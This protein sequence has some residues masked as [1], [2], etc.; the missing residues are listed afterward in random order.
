MTKNSVKKNEDLEKTNI[1]DVFKELKKSP[2]YNLSMSSLENFHTNFLVW[3]G[4]TYKKETLNLLNSMLSQREQKIEINEFKNIKFFSQE[5]CGKNCKFDLCVKNKD[6]NQIILILENKIKSYPTE[7][8][9]KKYD[10]GIEENNENFSNDCKKILLTLFPF[11]I[12]NQEQCEGWNV[13]TYSKLAEK[14]KEAYIEKDNDYYNALVTDYFNMIKKIVKIINIVEK[15]IEKKEWDEYN[16][17]EIAD[18]L[19]YFHDVYVKYRIDHLKNLIKEKIGTQQKQN[20]DIKLDFS[21]NS[22]AINIEKDFDN[23]CLYLQIQYNQYRYCMIFKD[24]VNIENQKKIVKKL[25]NIWFPSKEDC[26]GT[27]KNNEQKEFLNFGEQFVYR[28]KKIY[29]FS[30]LTEKQLK[31]KEKIKL[32]YVKYDDIIGQVLEDIQRL[33]E[34]NDQIIA[35]YNQILS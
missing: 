34:N 6:N 26:D 15:P 9:L 2:L 13:I 32:T 18:K 22:G 21:H 24:N 27:I 16:I 30:N 12:K 14:W 29:R 3:L 31:E 4:N 1:K 20:I 11:E 7:E 33:N 17:Y 19:E 28:Y 25:E 35:C 23:F 5:N 10:K 8:Q